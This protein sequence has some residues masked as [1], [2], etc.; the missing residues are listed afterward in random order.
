MKLFKRAW[1]QAISERKNP[2]KLHYNL[3]ITKLLKS[4]HT[5]SPSHSESIT[6]RS[7]SPEKVFTLRKLREQM[8]Q[9]RVKFMSWLEL[10]EVISGICQGRSKKSRSR[11]RSRSRTPS[12]IFNTARGKT[13]RTPSRAPPR[14][15][16]RRPTRVFIK[17]PLR[18]PRK[19]L[20][21]KSKTR[22]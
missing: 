9:L 6:E 4:T 21:S 12:R 17:S 19:F 22:R 15:P 8:S 7:I 10:A 16:T 20:R 14:I 13:T 2:H 1:K 18:T 11:S 5:Y 3:I